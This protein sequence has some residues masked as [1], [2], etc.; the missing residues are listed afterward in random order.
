[1]RKADRLRAPWQ[2]AW[3]IRRQA[4]LPYHGRRLL[5]ASAALYRATRLWL[6]WWRGDDPLELRL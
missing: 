6:W 2:T 1:M 5:S 4:R 3:P